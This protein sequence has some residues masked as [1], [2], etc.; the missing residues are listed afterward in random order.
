MM[1]DLMV[2]AHG[3]EETCKPNK[4]NRDDGDYGEGEWKMPI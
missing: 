1:R 2:L 4:N 3:V